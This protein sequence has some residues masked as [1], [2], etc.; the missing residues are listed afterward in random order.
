[1]PG[2]GGHRM[3]T[4]GLIEFVS[5]Y[6]IC[7]VAAFIALESIGI[8]LPA[9]AALMAAAFFAAR[10]RQLDIGLLIGAGIVAAVVGEVIGF[11]LGKRFG[12]HALTRYG[13]RLGLSERR[14]QI[15]QRVFVRYG[16]RFVF[17]AR[18]LPVLR[19]VAAVLAGANNMPQRNFYLAS[20][21]AAA[22]WVAFYGCAAYSLGEAFTR[23]ASLGASVLAVVALLIILAVPVLILRFEKSLMTNSD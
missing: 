17:I 14:L 20:G 16:G 12:R 10:T 13:A 19:N 11:W 6:G 23:L 2:L 18:F 5:A 7:L 21:A 22:A 3:F 1:L 9:E 4:P 15:G 8:P